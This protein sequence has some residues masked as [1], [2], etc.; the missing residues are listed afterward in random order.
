M[1]V[2]SLNRVYLGDHDHVY[3]VDG[4]SLSIYL[5]AAEAAGPGASQSHLSD[6]DI[7]PDDG[8]YIATSA[9][10]TGA[11]QRSG[12]VKSSAAHQAEWWVELSQVNE[13]QKLAVIADDYLAMVTLDGFWTLTPAGAQLVYAPAKLSS[14]SGCAR[15]DLVA[16]PS[17]V[18]LYQPG[19]SGYP[20]LR[21]NADG[22]GVGV[23]Y[24]TTVT[25]P[26]AVSADNFLC[27]ARDPSGGFYLLVNDVSSRAP[28]LYHVADDA[29]GT[30]GLTWIPTAGSFEEAKS[31]QTEPS[32]FDDCSIA[33]ARDGNVFIQTC[34]QL[35]RVWP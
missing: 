32:G 27:A 30:A 9:F 15:Q 19:C 1:A 10:F 34:H 23:L 17:G 29:Q 24:T 21:G 31:F 14:T 26:S 3:R 12:I 5:T 13:P 22:T 28:R 25:P 20:L 18:F 7:G 11:G 4:I 2:D 8:L 6:L 16:L 33:T 35:W